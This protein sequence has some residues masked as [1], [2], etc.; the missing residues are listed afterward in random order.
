MNRPA[1]VFYCCAAW[2]RNLPLQRAPQSNGFNLLALR[3]FP[4]ALHG[5]SCWE[6]RAPFRGERMCSRKKVGGKKA[7][8]QQPLVPITSP[9]LWVEAPGASPP[10]RKLLGPSRTQRDPSR[11]PQG[12]GC[13]QRW[14]LRPKNCPAMGNRVSG[15]KSLRSLGV[16]TGIASL[17]VSHIPLRW[18]NGPFNILCKTS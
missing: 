12:V 18:G 9:L 6:C 11:Y 16:P 10:P 14:E 7:Q 5:A 4:S 8:T 15:L 1:P 17:P 3:P 13:R 2:K